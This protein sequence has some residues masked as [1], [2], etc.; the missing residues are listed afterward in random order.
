MTITLSQNTPRVSYTVAAG[1]TQQ[2]FTVPFE[3]YSNTNI[4]VYV[5]GTLKTLT[6]DYTVTGGDG[7]TGSVVF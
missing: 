5:D 4:N 7:T 1:A 2:T 6:T 3:F